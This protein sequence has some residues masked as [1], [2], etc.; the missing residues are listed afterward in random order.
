MFM[1]SVQQGV[2]RTWWTVPK[3]IVQAK[4]FFRLVGAPT[5][6]QQGA[7]RYPS[8]SMRGIIDSLIG[9]ETWV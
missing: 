7:A 1:E 5:R 2:E 8:E 6:P 9:D 4:A 3:S